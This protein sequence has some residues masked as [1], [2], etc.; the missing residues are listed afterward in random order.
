MGTHPIFESDFDCLT[1]CWFE[2]QDRRLLVELEAT[3]QF[4]KQDPVSF[5]RHQDFR[6]RMI[7]RHLA[8]IFSLVDHCVFLSALF[9]INFLLGQKEL[10][11]TKEY[12]ALKY[13]TLEESD[14][15]LQMK[16]KAHR[17]S[18]A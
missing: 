16:L 14:T 17:L 12:V 9:L 15:L 3:N 1:E 4:F 13:A 11:T 7:F 5:T 6:M 8:N 10:L 18:L 2:Q